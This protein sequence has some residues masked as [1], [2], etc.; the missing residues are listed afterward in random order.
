MLRE[1]FLAET[2]GAVFTLF[3]RT[4]LTD[5]IPTLFAEGEIGLMNPLVP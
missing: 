4:I 5:T 2:A 1:T 3:F